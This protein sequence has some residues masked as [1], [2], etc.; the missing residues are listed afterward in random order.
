MM[1]VIIHNGMECL[2]LA[3]VTAIWQLLDY[4]LLLFTAVI[5]ILSS[6]TSVVFDEQK[7]A[8]VEQKSGY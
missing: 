8:F 5:F 2:K 3:Y 6:N 1:T 7:F 4:D